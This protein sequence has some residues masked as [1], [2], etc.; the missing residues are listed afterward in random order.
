LA[1][2][3]LIENASQYDAVEAEIITATPIEEKDTENFDNYD[4][5]YQKEWALNSL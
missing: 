1:K 3:V 5:K 2:I 4:E